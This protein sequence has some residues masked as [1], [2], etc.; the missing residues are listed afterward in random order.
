MALVPANEEV[1][2]WDVKTGELL[3]R[4]RESSATKSEVTVIAPSRGDADVVAVGYA[5]G[6]IRLWD[7][8]TSTVVISFNGHK[9][10][11]SAIAWDKAGTRIVS[12][13]RDADLILWDLVAEVG[14]CR[15]KGHRDMITGL[16]FLAVGEVGSGGEEREEGWVISTGKDALVKLWELE[17]RHCVETHLA[18]QGECWAMAVMPD[19]RGLV[20][21]GQDGEMKVWE[22]DLQSLPGRSS[23]DTDCLHDR[24]TIYRQIRDRTAGIKFHPD[25]NVFTV[26]GVDKNVEIWRIRSGDE[27]QRALKRKRKR[28]LEKIDDEEKEGEDTEGIVAASISDIFISYVV[29]RTGGKVKSVD[30]AV[31]PRSKSSRPVDQLLVSC[32]NNSLEFYSVERRQKEKKE[33]KTEAEVPDYNKLYT[34][35][36]PGHRTD[37]RA[38]SLSV[39]DRMLASAS[40]GSL[41]IWNVRTGACIRTFECGYALCCSFLPGDK[42]V[43]SIIFEGSNIENPSC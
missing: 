27:V 35:E 38:L 18:H 26:H 14:V 21:A 28:K 12:G 30:W 5:D 20:T 8:K 25:G 32:S 37:I 11:V 33:K 10:G 36:L 31:K 23:R 43:G 41:K 13:G 6:A 22:I 17:T 15:L 9:S 29:V 16:E 19:C 42:I 1:L 24:G 2:V 39:D 34:V 4:W 40:N 3:S 7:T